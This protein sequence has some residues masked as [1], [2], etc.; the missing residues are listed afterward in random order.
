MVTIGRPNLHRLDVMMMQMMQ[1]MGGWVEEAKFAQ[2]SK[3]SGEIECKQ[4]AAST[5][6]R[7]I[8]KI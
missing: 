5:Q 2:V 7:K 6:L 1:M 3:E 8:K 4:Q